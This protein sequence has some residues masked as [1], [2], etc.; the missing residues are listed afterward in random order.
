M[1]RILISHRFIINTIFIIHN[2]SNII[3]K[4]KKKKKKKV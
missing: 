4:K 1:I 2:H 3:K